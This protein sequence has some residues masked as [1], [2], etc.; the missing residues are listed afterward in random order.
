MIS[1]QGITKAYETEAGAYPALRGIDLEIGAGEVVAIVG[2]SGS[3]KSTLLHIIGG[4]DRPS[5]GTVAVDGISVQHLSEEQ[6][7]VWRGEKV[8][9]VFQFFQ[10]LPTLTAAENVMLPMDF[11]GSLPPRQRRPRALQLLERVGVLDH[12]DKLPSTLSGGELQRVAIARALANQPTVVLA[13]E[14]TGNLDSENARMILDL[15]RD[16]AQRGTTVVIA[17]HERDIAEL[18]DR[19]IR[20]ADGRLVDTPSPSGQARQQKL[21]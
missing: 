14:P 3:G 13:D 20:I 7:A 16:M 17:T 18:I 9:F 11:R 21:G 10:L 4:I 8:G 6:L 15:F 19:K 5:S 1:L 2:K 12:A